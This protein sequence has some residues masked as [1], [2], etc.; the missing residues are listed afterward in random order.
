M[1]AFTGETRMRVP[2]LIALCLVAASG[3]AKDKTKAVLP[4][5]VLRAQTVAVVIDPHAGFSIEDPEANH[6]AQKDVETALLNWGRYN[7]V[8]NMQTA[9]LIIVIRRGTG[10]LVD[11]TVRDPRQNNRPGS[12]NPMDDGIS[13]A[14]QHGP[15]PNQSGIEPGGPT[16]PQTEI[17]EQD[18]SFLVYEGGNSHPLDAAPV[19]RYVRKDA[20]IPHSVPAVD[21]FRR[22]VA[23]ADKA[24]AKQ[25]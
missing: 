6:T 17:G 8:L 21:A 11:N 23:D 13:A 1:V 16:S 20:L 14:A 5:Y 19:W 4:T 25:P 22:A 10:K 24:A 18:D 12:I 9:D 2:A 3:F 7:P 15:Q